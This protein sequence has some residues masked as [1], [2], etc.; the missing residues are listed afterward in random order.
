MDFFKTYYNYLT[1]E[2][3]Y[4]TKYELETRFLRTFYI[5]EK[6]NFTVATVIKIWPHLI[7]G[8]TLLLLIVSNMY[9]NIMHFR[10][11]T[12]F[13]MSMYKESS[14][15]EQIMWNSPVIINFET[16]AWCW[17]WTWKA[18][19]TWGQMFHRHMP[20]CYTCDRFLPVVCQPS[21]TDHWATI[22]LPSL[23][24]GFQELH[25]SIESKAQEKCLA[26]SFQAVF[27]NLFT[28]KA[29]SNMS[30][31]RF[32]HNIKLSSSLFKHT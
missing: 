3:W 10:S 16:W 1:I 11:K 25:L 28:K 24:S 12:T 15:L 5:K 27:K 14:F 31:P 18:Y 29:H 17:S 9:F 21:D 20:A 6:V 30:K 19:W 22:I 13:T 2:C 7:T 26:W 8:S 32:L 4:L 23:N